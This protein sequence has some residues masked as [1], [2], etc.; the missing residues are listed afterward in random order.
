MPKEIRTKVFNL[1]NLQS[2]RGRRYVDRD[3]GQTPIAAVDRRSLTDA[4]A[5]AVGRRRS[6]RGRAGRRRR[7]GCHRFERFVVEGRYDRRRRGQYENAEDPETVIG[8]RRSR[9]VLLHLDT[10]LRTV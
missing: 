7:R 10:S 6:D 4:F 8:R 1:I 3:G 9:P 5:R 2:F